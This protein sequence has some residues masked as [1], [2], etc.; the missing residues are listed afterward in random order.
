LAA[1]GCAAAGELPES[2]G[3]SFDAL[4]AIASS[5][6]RRSRKKVARL[7]GIAGRP[8]SGSLLS[9]S[10]FIRRR[11]YRCAKA[12]RSL[13]LL[14]SGKVFGAQYLFPFIVKKKGSFT[15][16]VTPGENRHWLNVL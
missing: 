13:R 3:A 1:H 7:Q 5:A 2:A 12:P 11:V 14:I 9:F 10:C 4:S 16:S 6:S 8:C 15:G